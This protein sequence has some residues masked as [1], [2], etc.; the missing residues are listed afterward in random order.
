G[1]DGHGGWHLHLVGR[2]RPPRRQV[3]GRHDPGGYVATGC[4]GWSDRCPADQ[5]DLAADRVDRGTVDIH[6]DW[7][8]RHLN[9]RCLPR[10]SGWICEA[11]DPRHR[12]GFDALSR[13]DAHFAACRRATTAGNMMIAPT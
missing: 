7:P 13:V 10:L 11:V 5:L 6:R 3:S 1:A 4:K 2:R 12:M 8:R 9:G